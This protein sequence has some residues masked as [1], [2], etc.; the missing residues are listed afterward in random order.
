MPLQRFSHL[1]EADDMETRKSHPSSRRFGLGDGVILIGALALG[2][3]SL[4]SGAWFDRIPQRIHFWR[5][6]YSELTGH[7]PQPLLVRY[8]RKYVVRLVVSEILDETF[9]QLLGPLVWGLTMAQPLLRLRSPR[10]PLRRVVREAG[11]V[12][13]VAALIGY[14]VT[15]DVQ[16]IGDIVLPPLSFVAI[17]LLLAWP[18][19]GLPPWHAE[20]NWI[21]RLGRAVGLGWIVVE[22][23]GAAAASVLRF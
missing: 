7:I 6:A 22:A 9:Q 18:A 10:P 23:G 17:A 3:G 11:F 20:P 19:L 16:L 2:L 15:L 12:T 14:F 5:E 13:C 4:R 8:P 1:S 21:D